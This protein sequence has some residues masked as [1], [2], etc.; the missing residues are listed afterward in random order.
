M[1]A[2]PN[3][4]MKNKINEVRAKAFNEALLNRFR[5]LFDPLNGKK[6]ESKARAEKAIPPA[7]I[8]FPILIDV[9]FFIFIMITKKC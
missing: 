2:A 8:V 3:S 5:P 9:S 6:Y 1:A 4:A 7:N